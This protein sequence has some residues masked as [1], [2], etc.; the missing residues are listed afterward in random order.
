[1]LSY[2]LPDKGS[3]KVYIYAGICKSTIMAA[4]SYLHVWK[5]YIFS[6]L[7]MGKVR[8]NIACGKVDQ[9]MER[10]KAALLAGHKYLLQRQSS[11]VGQ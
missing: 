8:T 9:L 3:K 2:K 5:V 10:R 11:T 4:K 6:R 7:N 1:M